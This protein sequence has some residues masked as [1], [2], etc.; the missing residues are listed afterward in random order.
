MAASTGKAGAEAVAH[1]SR[2]A[3]LRRPATRDL[4][5]AG[6]FLLPALAA[7]VLFRL[8]PLAWAVITSFQ[9]T[10]GEFAGFANYLFVIRGVETLDLVR[11]TLLFAA[12]TV[13]LQTGFAL[14]AALLL[15]QPFRGSSVLRMLIFLPVTLPLAG[16]AIFWNVALEQ[17]GL[18]NAVLATVH[19]PPQPFLSSVTEALPAIVVM[20]L[21]IGVGYSMIFLIA[22][23]QDVPEDYYEAA[24]LDGA[25]WLRM[26]WHVTLPLVRRPLLFV[27]VSNTIAAF[28]TFAPAQILTQGG[29]DSTTDFVMWDIYQRSYIFNDQPAAMAELVLLMIVMLALVTFQFRLLQGR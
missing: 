24:A 15:T 26:T 20:M 11:A 28:V 19:L 10:A 23:V 29:P 17:R 5:V 2:F 6:V 12:A 27:A 18:V 8:L 7:M 22:G 16:S 21:W 1:R 9:T 14:V 4:L 3:A 13:V 25:G